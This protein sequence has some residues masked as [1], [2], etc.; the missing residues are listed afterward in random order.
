M[1]T[2]ILLPKLSDEMASATIVRW[3][4]QVGETVIETEVIAE[5]KTEKAGVDLEAPASG[6][7]AS[8]LVPEGSE[9]VA[10]GTVLATIELAGS[11]KPG[12]SPQSADGV[13]PAPEPT[14]RLA[15]HQSA[16]STAVS[17]A[18]PMAVSKDRATATER[19]AGH[20]SASTPLA[21]MMA[22]LAGLEVS[23]IA[24]GSSGAVTRRQVE[25][26]LGLHQRPAKPCKSEPDT[27]QTF[28]TRAV[29]HN[30]IR[31]LT[32]ARMTDAKEKIP[33]FY[34]GIECD[35]ERA[36]SFLKRLNSN[37]P[38][39]R[40][41]LTTLII[42]TAG[43]ALQRVPLLNAEFTPTHMVM[44]KVNIAVAVATPAGLVAPVIKNVNERCCEGLPQKLEELVERAK[45]TRLRL[46][47]SAGGTF[48]VSNLGMFGVT[49]VVPIITPGQ[50]G[51]LGIGASREAPV[52]RDGAVVVSKVMT[53]TLSGDHRAL[54]GAQGAEFLR[55]FK[56]LIEE[57]AR[58]I[59]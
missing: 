29:P 20:S 44:R 15:A 13:L 47:D 10:I 40:L 19:K 18:V 36:T 26:A 39:T 28:P 43:V 38:P 23:S 57:P 1:V 30:T 46:Q 11:Y 48:T 41:T 49:S 5:L 7:L 12:E 21:S 25:E 35:V 53:A 4:K 9:E 33:H 34:L 52:I 45:A 8:I 58:L 3:L 17:A 51:V 59:L 37:D 54:D 56:E 50:S 16:M 6:V 24:A 32:A 55:I 14:V 27:G 2:E 22:Q 42:K 31:K